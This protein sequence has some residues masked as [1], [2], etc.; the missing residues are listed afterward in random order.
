MAELKRQVGSACRESQD[1]ASEL[2]A[3]WAE[4]QRAVEWATAAEQGLEAMKAR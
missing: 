1:R 4:G 3:V 2:A